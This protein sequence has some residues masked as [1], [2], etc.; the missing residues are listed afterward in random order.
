MKI[1]KN[2]YSDKDNKH[3]GNEFFSS[4]AEANRVWVA[5]HRAG[6]V[7]DG[8]MSVRALT[9]EVKPR[10]SGLIALLNQEATYRSNTQPIEYTPGEGIQ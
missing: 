10:K 5:R 1:Y 6:D 8:D 2:S 4:K 3:A 9:V 7:H